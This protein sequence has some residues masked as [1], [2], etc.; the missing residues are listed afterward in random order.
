LEYIASGDFPVIYIDGAFQTLAV[1]IFKEQEN[2]HTSLFDC[3]N[4]AVARNL[5]IPK[6]FSFDRAYPK[7]FELSLATV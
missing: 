4:V 1:T 2:K 5:G 7:K 6:I 3:A